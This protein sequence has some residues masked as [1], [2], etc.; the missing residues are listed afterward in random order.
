[1]HSQLAPGQKQHG[2]RTHG[3]KL[4]TSWGQGAER[5]ERSWGRRSTLPNYTPSD[6]PLPTK[7]YFLKASQPS[8]PHKSKSPASEHVRLGGTTQLQTITVPIFQLLQGFT[9]KDP[10]LCP[11][12]TGCSGVGESP[13]LGG[14][15]IPNDQVMLRYKCPCLV[16][17]NSYPRTTHEIMPRVDVF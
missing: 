14:W 7:P 3:G 2:R 8:D 12:V 16:T 11:S 10:H 15:I 4:L 6:P 1:M 5:E 9:N 13:C 17:S